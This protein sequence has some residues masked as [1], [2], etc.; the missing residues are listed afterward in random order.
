[1]EIIRG[2]YPQKLLF[3]WD[4]IDKCQ[5]DCE[6]CYFNNRDTLDDKKLKIISNIVLK[7]LSTTNEHFDIE[8]L[9]GEPT[10]HLYLENILETLN[11][12]VF[13][14]EIRIITNF[15]KSNDYYEDLFKYDKLI[16]RVSFHPQYSEDILEKLLS[17]KYLD[18]TIITVNISDKE[19]FLGKTKRFIKGLN[20]NNIKYEINY[21]LSNHKYNVNYNDKTLNEIHSIVKKDKIIKIPY[22]DKDSN[23]YMIEELE[24][25][26]ISFRDWYCKPVIYNIDIFGNIKNICYNSSIGLKLNDLVKII[27]CNHDYCSC[28]KKLSFEKWKI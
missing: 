11:N 1:M 23:K 6:Y 12:N 10:L 28:S 19:R 14:D 25:F 7:K 24:L 27:K 16:L 20:D 8:L 13:C 4:L 18:K 2:G 5:F 15:Y 21:L 3:R 26:K 9:G 22:Y 17:F